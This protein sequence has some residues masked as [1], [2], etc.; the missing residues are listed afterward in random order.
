MT[1]YEKIKKIIEDNNGYLLTSQVVDADISKTYLSK[2]VRENNLEKV[3]HGI[4]VEQDIWPDELYILQL[5]NPKV[6]YAGE[7]A[8][9]LH[10]M[11]DCEY[12]DIFVTVPSGHN[13]TRLNEKGIKVHQEPNDIYELGVVEVETNYGHKVKTYDRERCI[14]DL[15]IN[16]RLFEVQ[17]FQ[18]AMKG[19][20]RSKDKN[21]TRLI[22][23]AEK[24]N[25]RDEVMKYVEVLT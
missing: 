3:A 1:K 19:Y 5:K 16:R 6:V 9:Y 10:E 25:I 21:L 22:C 20:M 7:T 11:I 2:Y 14:C 24:L 13:R 23:Y 4:Y 8:L 17:H 18:S 15:I 12:S